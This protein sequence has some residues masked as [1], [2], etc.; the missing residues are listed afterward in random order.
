MIDE[1]GLGEKGF[2]M[3]EIIAV[4]VL[5]GVVS[6]LLIFRSSSDQTDE[7]S[8]ADKLKVHLRYAQMR[9]M[10]SDV[11]WGVQFNGGSYSLM[12]NMTG[13]PVAETLPGEINSS[14]SLP[15]VVTGSVQFDTWGRPTGMNT[16][17]LGSVTITITPDT[18]F[19]P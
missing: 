19:I 10:N 13:T 14:V 1:H 6:A 3:I 4:L 2:T 7:S 17:G 15:T 8:S 12:Q 5:L 18:G 16:I 9:S 11:V